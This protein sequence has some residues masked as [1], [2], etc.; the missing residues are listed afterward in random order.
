[1]GGFTGV[2]GPIGRGC[3]GAPGAEAPL[4]PGAGPLMSPGP[5]YGPGGRWP[6]PGCIIRGGK[7][8][9]RTEDIGNQKTYAKMIIK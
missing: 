1:M 2:G 8:P 4:A 7:P 6:M 3:P 9:G 5:G